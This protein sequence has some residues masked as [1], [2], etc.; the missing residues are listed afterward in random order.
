V[1]SIIGM[2]GSASHVAVQVE[3]R[4]TWV[5]IYTYEC[6]SLPM[7]DRESIDPPVL[8]HIGTNSASSGRRWDRC[9][10][11]KGAQP[12]RTSI[13]RQRLARAAASAGRRRRW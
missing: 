8:T 10:G 3:T 4:V 1:A 13:R 9:K 5:L 2:V 6:F 12:A 11:A 7:C